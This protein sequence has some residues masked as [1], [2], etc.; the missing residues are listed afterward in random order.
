MDWL[1]VVWRGRGETLTRPWIVG[2]LLLVLPVGAC[3]D[4]GMDE[5]GHGGTGPEQDVTV[6]V[7]TEPD[8]SAET[9]P[10]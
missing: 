4:S 1:K 9:A 5:D 3:T 10:G 7:A 6:E 2:A 8:A